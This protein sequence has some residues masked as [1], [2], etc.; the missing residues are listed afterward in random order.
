MR[1][2]FLFSLLAIVLALWVT[3]YLGFPADPG[4]L[5]IAFGNYTFE[6]SLF[7]LLVAGVIVYVVI[8]LLAIV[9]RALN[10]WRWFRAGREFAHR[11]RSHRR[12]RTVEGLLYLTRRNWQAAYGSLTKSAHD[13]DASVINY[14]GAA[15]A[16]FEL[17]ERDKWQHCLL[18]AEKEYPAAHTTIHTLKAQLL[19]RSGQLEQCLA[20]VEMLRKNALNDR[21]L[22]AL[23]KDV[24]RDLGEWERL[25]KLLPQLREHDLVDDAE[26]KLIRNRVLGQQLRELADAAAQAEEREQ[27]L[28]KMQKLW[29]KAHA[30]ARSDADLVRHY[31]DLLWELGA[32]EEAA[33]AIEKS[34]ALRWNPALVLRYGERDYGVSNRQLLA[35]EHWLKSRPGDPQLLLTLGRLSMRNQLWG[36]A[37]KYYESS[38]RVAPSVPAYAELSRLLKHLGEAAASEEYLAHYGE[39]IGSELPVLPLPEPPPRLS[40]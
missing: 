31:S 11:R 10:P 2:L 22:L 33:E 32:R 16:A 18:E 4:Y 21:P 34:L 8:R 15:T 5:L 17:G 12:S 38:I 28:G 39:L 6:T 29:K 3:L 14:L 23:L 1:R 35:A 20:V 19:Y 37:R 25:Q 36:K 27:A 24:Y 13:D 9:L 40:N 30:A 26:E 7:A